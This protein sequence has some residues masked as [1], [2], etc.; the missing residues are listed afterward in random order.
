MLKDKKVY[1]VFEGGQ[2]VELEEDLARPAGSLVA[3]QMI[4]A[5]QDPSGKY[6]IMRIE[7]VSGRPPELHYHVKKFA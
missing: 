3:A 7:K 2:I 1:I 6:Q 5:S 4:G